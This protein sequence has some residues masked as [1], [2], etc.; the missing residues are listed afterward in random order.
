MW[1]VHYLLA[2]FLLIQHIQWFFKIFLID[3]YL[4]SI[5]WKSHAY[6]FISFYSIN[7]DSSII[8]R[9]CLILNIT[10]EFLFMMQPKNKYLFISIFLLSH[11]TL[12]FLL[13]T[14]TS[15][16]LLWFLFQFFYL[17]FLHNLKIKN[18]DQSRIYRNKLSRTT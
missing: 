13:I 14:I 4:L 5:N 11:I 1:Y 6:Y 8:K 10:N 3:F 12:P 7:A 9:W 17:W 15:I 2:L 18:K 16:M